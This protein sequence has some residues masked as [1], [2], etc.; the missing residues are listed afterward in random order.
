MRHIPK[1]TAGGLAAGIGSGFILPTC[2]CGVVPI[3]RRLMRK[4][5]PP[6]MAI[7]YMLAAPIVN[8]VV[9]A[10]TYLAFR[11]SLT[12]VLARI[13]VAALTTTMLGLYARRLH[14]VFLTKDESEDHA[15][16]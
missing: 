6:F 1:S 9:L 5:V 2:E 8:P 7:A 10:S 14:D 11:G 4:G 16:F 3:V 12:M 13:A 15:R